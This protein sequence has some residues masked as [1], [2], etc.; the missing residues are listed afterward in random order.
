MATIDIKVHVQLVKR[1]KS[2]T[3]YTNKMIIGTEKCRSYKRNGLISLNVFYFPIVF[4][5]FYIY[6]HIQLNTILCKQKGKMVKSQVLKLIYGSP[7]V[8]R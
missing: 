7:L 8:P 6:K 2:S 3:Q 1:V 5:C 4:V